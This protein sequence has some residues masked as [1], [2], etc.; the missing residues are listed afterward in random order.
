VF[1]WVERVIAAPAFTHHLMTRSTARESGSTPGGH[2][3]RAQSAH[4]VTCASARARSVNPIP[5]LDRAENN[6]RTSWHF[7]TG[8]PFPR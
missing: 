7:M 4:A 8:T 3:A 2:L 1:I 6:S 5:T